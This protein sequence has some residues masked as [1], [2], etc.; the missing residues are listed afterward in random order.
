MN[1]FCPKRLPALL[2]SIFICASATGTLPNDP[3]LPARYTEQVKLPGDETLSL[4]MVLI[5]G[6][7]FSMGSP[8][9]EADRKENEGPAHQVS[10]SPFY[11]ATTETTMELFLVF[12]R[13]TVTAARPE[14]YGSA[15]DDDVDTVSGPTPVYG[16]MT[17]GR[18]TRHPAIGM[19]WRNA[20]RFCRWLSEKTG[21]EYRLPT[22]AEWEYACR[23]GS[24]SSFGPAGDPSGLGKTAWFI[25][26]S[27][28]RPHEV[29]SREPNPW[30]LFDMQGNVREWV[31]DFY[32]PDAYSQPPPG[33]KWTNPKGPESG[34]VH[35][36]RGGDYRSALPALRCAARDYE[37]RFWRSGDPQMPKS[38]W[39]LPNMDIIGFRVA[40]SA[41]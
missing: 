5:R 20:V 3:R 33:G 36:A 37:Q 26:N 32:S 4:D 12:Y 41:E 10:L 6:G 19:T 28:G 11:L 17:M 35:V 15:T 8:E 39:W 14:T 21:K 13:E 34:R 22:E 18:N 40:R 29:G 24:S 31:L 23:A 16:D 25:Q 38:R 1:H 7:S 2:L 30:G 27:Q 9:G